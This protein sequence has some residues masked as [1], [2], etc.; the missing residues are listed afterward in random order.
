MD[1]GGYAGHFAT[2]RIGG[3]R[4]SAFLLALVVWAGFISA[5]GSVAA[6]ATRVLSFRHFST[7]GYTRLV[8]VL[9]R[10]S[11]QFRNGRL[12]DPPRIFVDI[13]SGRLQSGIRLPRFKKASLARKLRVGRPDRKRMRLVIEL[14]HAEIRHRVFTLPEPAR[15]VIDLRDARPAQAKMPTE[16]DRI[17][18]K[19]PLPRAIPDRQ[20]SRPEEPPPAGAPRSMRERRRRSPNMT[21][22][23]RAGLGR[24]VLD[25][26]HGGRD[27]GAVG[28]YGLTEKRLVLD[29]SRRISRSLRRLLPPGNRVILTRTRD[30]FLDLKKRTAVANKHDADVFV[31]IHVNSSPIRS[32]RGVETYLLAEASTKRALR[33]AARESGT[34]V[35][36]M[37][38]LQKILGDLTLRS[39]VTESH[40]LANHVQG[41]I[42]SRLIETYS[43]IN[44]LGVK[45]GPFYVLV[46]AQMPSILVEMAFLTNR[47]EARR[48]KTRKFRQNIAEGIAMGIFKFIGVSPQRASVSGGRENFQ[49]T[50]A[51]RP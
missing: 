26:G 50:E 6:G 22:R 10:E 14:R 4:P 25:P 7:E 15:I 51:T 8:F 32:T 46:G 24:I 39:K 18:D 44:D 13:P 12:N 38:D 40:Q 42:I 49:N 9:N 33:L 11:N 3:L 43:N 27:P 29:I 20:V 17:G 41:A 30:R 16:R 34:T 21:A 37:S 2:R 36:E 45:R 1:C 5:S 28:L 31:S 23:F 35:S 47:S 48:L 19:S